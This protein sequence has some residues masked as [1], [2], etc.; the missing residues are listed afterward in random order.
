MSLLFTLFFSSVIALAMIHI[1]ALKFF[2]YWKYFWLD[3]PMHI[4]GGITC[5]LGFV[6]CLSRNKLTTAWY[7]SLWGYLSFTFFIG[8]AWELFEVTSGFSIIDEHFVSD[9]I[10]D[11][12]M[13]ILGGVI[14]YA[15]VNTI[16]KLE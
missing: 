13:D 9:T 7:T 14:G 1:V 3:I 12:S 16:R 4:F 10:T 15:I 2:L 6:I 5:A 11:L 8:I